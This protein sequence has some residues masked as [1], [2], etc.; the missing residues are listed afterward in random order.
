[1][2]IY[3]GTKVTRKS[4]GR[5]AD[6]CFICRDFR[7]FQGAK[8]ER[9]GHLYGL[10]V[11]TRSTVGFTR[12]CEACGSAFRM[13]P[14]VYPSFSKDKRAGLDALM[15][16]TQPQIWENWYN[17]LQI[18]RRARDGKL[19][20]DERRE[21]ILEPFMLLNYRVEQQ[22]SSPSMDLKV[23]L[24]L[25]A[26]VASLIYAL[27]FL[28]HRSPPQGIVPKE[29]AFGIFLA[30]MAFFSHASSTRIRRYTKKHI[31][32]MITASLRPIGPTAM[33]LEDAVRHL[34]RIELPIGKAARIEDIREAFGVDPTKLA[35]PQ[36]AT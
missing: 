27:S 4:I 33:E 31:L 25:L 9:G 35:Y 17:R 7:P 2:F 16:E 21:L 13:Q 34:K 15:S 20:P 6:F 5:V 23:G 22:A 32:P 28:G 8:I 14:E 3:W 30:S 10:S 26:M 11:G 24:G 19:T 1:M 12:K 29:V 18:E 36:F